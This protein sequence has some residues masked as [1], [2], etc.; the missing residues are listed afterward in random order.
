MVYEAVIGLEVHVQ[1]KS[2]S[3]IFC[4]CSTKFGAMA[5]SQT[6]P[7]CL[8]LPG[9]LPVLNDQVVALAIKTALS[10]NCLISPDCQFHRKNYFYP[11]LPKNYQIS[12]YDQPL[13][14]NGYLEIKLNDE[15]KRIGITRAHLEEDAG[16]LIHSEDGYSLIDLNRC[17]LPLLEIVSQPD[18]RTPQE[19]YSY[20]TTLELI[21][22]YIQTCDCNM[23]E[24]SIRCD[25]N[26]SVRRKGDS[27]LGTKTEI[28]NLN[29]FRAVEQSLKY[30]ISRQIERLQENKKVIQE[31]RLWDE[32]KQITHSMR[33]KEE[34]HDYRYFPEPDL[35][36][37]KLSQEWIEEI[38]AALPELPQARLSRFVQDYGLPGYDAAVLTAE[39]DLADFYE[40]TVK[41]CQKPKLVSNWVM[42]EVLGALSETGRT[43]AESNL[44]SSHLAE[45]IN[46]IEEGRISGKIG[47][48]VLFEM[49]KSGK[50]PGQI[51][52]EKGL[53]QI[54][55][56]AELNKMVAEVIRENSKAV[57]EYQTGKKEVL[58]FLVG[59]I[60]RKSRGKANP[61]IVNNLLTTELLKFVD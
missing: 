15:I 34:A 1:L 2:E 45:M 55:D 21:L 35:V 53:E 13:A 24:G 57:R 27:Q 18:L 61:Q 40:E 25:A 8:G 49:L 43:I 23:E 47:K 31:T 22:E 56:E 48:D 28:K 12:Q 42:T 50:R 46:L 30:E 10:L 26:V 14:K 52:Q 16:K 32:K 37:L 41:L 33:L 58:G 54:S 7:V 11:D 29:S 9:V 51:I 6:C 60:M 20:L 39:K 44:S 36:P 4:N 59:Q 5:N 17:G 38:K 19:A 3:K